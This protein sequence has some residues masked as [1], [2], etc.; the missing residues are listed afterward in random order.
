VS[1]SSARPD[2]LIAY[3][4]HTEPYIDAAARHIGGIDE[5]IAHL[6]TTSGEYLPLR[7]LYRLEH[8]LQRALEH[9]RAVDRRVADV[10]RAFLEA[11]GT[12]NAGSN[13]VTATDGKLAR[14]SAGP[15]TWVRDFYVAGFLNFWHGDTEGLPAGQSIA[16]LSNV[17]GIPQW[18][19]KVHPI[20]SRAG[21]RFYQRWPV[22]NDHHRLF[23]TANNSLGGKLVTSVA[24]GERLAP[25]QRFT[26]V[27]PPRQLVAVEAIG[28]RSQQFAAW[29]RQPAT[30]VMLKRA[31]VVGGGVSTVLDAKQLVDHGDPRKAFQREGAGYV[32]DVARTGFSA[33]STAF[34]VA[35]NPVTGAAVVG[36]GVVWAGAEIW[37][38]WDDITDL[39]DETWDRATE[40]FDA[41]VERVED[42]L[43]AGREAL[44]DVGDTVSGLA[45]R[46]GLR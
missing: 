43:Q 33:S 10:G 39:A 4:G 42:A 30:T 3:A 25:L 32:A 5:L 24:S 38:N 20:T 41:P 34:L 1:T 35:P 22:V 29:M 46:F 28:A 14:G 18:L 31:G 12:E 44:D 2:A 40:L 45:G 27:I 7:S 23:P 16:A 8:D 37:D 9:V 19:E 13:L 11:D 6:R 26:S 21:I 15:L 17:K 36:T